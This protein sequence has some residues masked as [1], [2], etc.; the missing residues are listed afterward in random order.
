MMLNNSMDLS[1]DVLQDIAKTYGLDDGVTLRTLY[2]LR[3][4]IGDAAIERYLSDPA[5]A[6]ALKDI[7]N[8]SLSNDS[9]ELMDVYG[10]LAD[11]LGLKKE[12]IRKYFDNYSKALTSDM[13]DDVY[14]RKKAC[15]ASKAVDL[16]G[17]AVGCFNTN[18][19][20]GQ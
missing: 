12:I 14:D 5:N 2:G 3:N 9:V 18:G 1:N 16:T 11:V 4:S 15:K 13:F 10:G 7:R 17:A 20:V 6:K 8:C 19:V